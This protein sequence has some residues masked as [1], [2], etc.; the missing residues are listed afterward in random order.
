MLQYQMNYSSN[1]TVMLSSYRLSPQKAQ[2][3]LYWVT[4]D[5][6]CFNALFASV[7]QLALGFKV[8]ENPSCSW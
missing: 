7:V 6:H 4:R 2:K 3:V 5:V 8:L 1:D